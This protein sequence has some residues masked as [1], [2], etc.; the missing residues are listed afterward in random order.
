M[1]N[2]IP[3]PSL[4]VPPLRSSGLPPSLLLPCPCS[5]SCCSSAAHARPSW[6]SSP[7]CFL[8]LPRTVGFAHNGP[9]TKKP[10]RGDKKKEVGRQNAPTK[11]KVAPTKWP[12]KK[13]IRPTKKTERPDIIFASTRQNRSTK[14]IRPLRLC[15]SIVNSQLRCL[16]PGRGPILSDGP[17]GRFVRQSDRAFCRGSPV[18]LRRPVRRPSP[19]GRAPVSSFPRGGPREVREAFQMVLYGHEGR[20]RGAR[21]AAEKGS[22]EAP[23]RPWEASARFSR[24]S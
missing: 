3:R 20:P 15:G 13:N 16:P 10:E 22:R 8:P 23:P 17:R 21:E 14:K 11:K 24:G 19:R 18:A 2:A 1:N 4:P 12:T 7:A 5:S 9:T 6:P